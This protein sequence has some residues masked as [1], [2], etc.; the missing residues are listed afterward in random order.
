[1]MSN[2]EFENSPEWQDFV[3]DVT[4]GLV[5][6]MRGSAYVCSVVPDGGTDVKFAVQLGMSIMMDKPIIAIVRPGTSVPP[7]LTLIADRI[8]EADL[9]SEAGAANLMPRL[10]A[11]VAELEAEGKGGG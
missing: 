3:A 11:A 1:M 2:D 4:E 9:S 10:D 7:K 8:L 5:P 6:K